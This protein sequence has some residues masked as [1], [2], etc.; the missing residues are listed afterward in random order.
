MAEHLT[1]RL[2]DH[3]HIGLAAQGVPKLPLHHAKGGFH[4]AALVVVLQEFLPL[5]HEV[6]GTSLPTFR[7]RSPCDAR[8]KQC[9]ERL[10]CWQRC[11]Y[12]FDHHNLCPPRLRQFES[13][14]RWL[15]RV[16]AAAWS[17]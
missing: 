2:V 13:S 10:P 6:V 16:A 9:K 7:H 8:R 4:V 11:S 5:E 3:R 1:E 17:R 12:Y 15:P 14:V